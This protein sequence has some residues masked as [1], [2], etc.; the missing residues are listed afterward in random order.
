MYISMDLAK[1]TFSILYNE[2]YRENLKR[3][4]EEIERHFGKIDLISEEFYFNFLENYYGREMGKPLKK[5]YLS[6]RDL[7]DKGQLVDIKLKSM[8]VE[9]ELSVRGNRTVN[10]D[11]GYLDETQLI[12][13]SH[14]RRGARIYLSREIYAEVELLYV[15]GAFRPLYW[16]YPDYRHTAV[17]EFFKKVRKK[18]LEERK[19]K[20]IL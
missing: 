6:L 11:P 10:L 15:Y 8:E 12:L 1:F 18:F 17:R 20:N 3:A 2:N 14:K 5:L 19:L 13:A 9:K 7:K 4:L 16:T